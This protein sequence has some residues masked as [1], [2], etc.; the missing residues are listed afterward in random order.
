M[1]GG[2]EYGI[3][4]FVSSVVDGSVADDAGLKVAIIALDFP[5]KGVLLFCRLAIRLSMLTERRFCTLQ[6]KKLFVS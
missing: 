5:N 4:I 2:S 6:T 3:G 1:R